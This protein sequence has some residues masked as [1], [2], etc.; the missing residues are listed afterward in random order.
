MSKDCKELRPSDGANAGIHGGGSLLSL[1]DE[2][3]SEFALDGCDGR[4]FAYTPRGT[5]D[6]WSLS[7]SHGGSVPGNRG[8]TGTSPPR[9]C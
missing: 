6:G 2:G 1:H 7:L 5:S 3:G 9:F 4:G 8:I